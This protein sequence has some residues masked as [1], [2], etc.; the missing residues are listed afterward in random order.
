LKE[1]TGTPAADVIAQE[2]RQDKLK[3]KKEDYIRKYHSRMAKESLVK[4]FAFNKAGSF[5]ADNPVGEQLPRP[6]KE[7]RRSVKEL[8]PLVSKLQGQANPKERTTSNTGRQRQEKASEASAAPEM[9]LLNNSPLNKVP[10]TALNKVREVASFN[11]KRVTLARSVE[12]ERVE[13]EM[14]VAEN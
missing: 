8:A 14:L 11:E 6:S 12:T 10:N 7:M 9:A 3:R 13:S 4:G 1:I 5:V 2:L